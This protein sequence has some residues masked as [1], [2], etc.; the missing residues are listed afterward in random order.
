[1]ST[2]HGEA[3]ANLIAKMPEEGP[4]VLHLRN[5][6]SSERDRL[7]S[8]GKALPDGSFPIAN[9]SDLRNAIQAYG[10]ASDKEKAKR[11]IIKRARALGRTDLLP[12][13]WT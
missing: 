12:E 9:E 11:H 7:S 8:E 1:M 6:S 10:R 13:D 5:V 4:D 2:E 3:V